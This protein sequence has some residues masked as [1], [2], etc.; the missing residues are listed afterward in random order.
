M[1]QTLLVVG[2][3][4]FL[5]STVCRTAV[6]R[7]WKVTSISS[8]GRPFQTP[9]GHSP[10]WVSQVDWRAA[11]AFE[12]HMYKDLL[13]GS[14]AVV[15]CIG[16]LFEDTSYKQAVQ[17]GNLSRLF[18][19]MTSQANPL[20]SGT[21]ESSYQR[22]N[23]E[24][25]M[26]VLDTYLKVSSSVPTQRAFVYISAEDI[27]GPLVP[28]GYINSKRAAERDIALSCLNSP[29]AGVQ[30]ISLRPGLMYHPHLR[31]L[32]TP[33]ATVLSASAQAHKFL[34]S[35]SLPLPTPAG[36]LN[37]LAS[38][39]SFQRPQTGH[40]DAPLLETLRSSA[41]ALQIPPMH[42]DHVGLAACLAIE[43]A[44]SAA[45]PSDTDNSYHTILGVSE[46]RDMIG[47]SWDEGSRTS[48]HSYS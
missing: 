14:S 41:N 40:G 3:N 24:S 29:E 15:H 36:F 26:T 6:K 27:F 21:S 43:D 22:L 35:N 48:D 16:T 9:K 31:P 39:I 13:A 2:G 47:W 34:G 4:G 42:V 45:P 46:M 20:R 19:A 23:Y 38:V 11:S 37:T 18:N 5:G 44:V 10:A 1:V 30:P 12:P 33:I 17:S 28:R 7:G 25:A 8:S 32:T